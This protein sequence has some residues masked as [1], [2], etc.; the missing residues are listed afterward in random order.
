MGVGY[1]LQPYLDF[2]CRILT[3]QMVLDRWIRRGRGQSGNASRVHGRGLRDASMCTYA[4]QDAN[5]FDC[6]CLDVKCAC[7]DLKDRGCYAKSL[8]AGLR[9]S[10]RASLAS[11][12][13]GSVVD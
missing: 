9:T 3:K 7:W 8:H 2:R 13:P 1:S 12:G 4:Y 5:M 10:A 6:A 11:R